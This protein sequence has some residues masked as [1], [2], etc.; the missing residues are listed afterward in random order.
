MRPTDL[1]VPGEDW[2]EQLQAA[3]DHGEARLGRVRS[4][5]P[6]RREADPSGWSVRNADPEPRQG[7]RLR[8]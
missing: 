1:P 6:S 8:P 4:R 3:E 5:T 2:D 7:K